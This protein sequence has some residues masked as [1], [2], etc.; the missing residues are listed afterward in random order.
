MKQVI[1]Q[2]GWGLDQNFWDIDKVEF[3]KNNWVWQDNERGYFSKNSNQSKW[4][5][6]SSNHKI[7][8]IICHS[9][10]FHL[11]EEN[12]FREASHI[13]LINSFNDFLP[14]SKKRN[15][16]IRSLRRMEKQIKNCKAKSMLK[17][18]INRSFIPNSLN[19]EFQTNYY[20][21]LETIDKSI[22]LRDFKKLYLPGDLPKF[23][24]KDCNIIFI[25]SE[26]DLILDK[27]SSNNFLELL[28]KTLDKTPALIRLENQG[29][30]LTNVNLYEII[31]N[32]LDN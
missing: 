32:N 17:E 31:I 3:E 6:N 12:L 5:S 28:N 27:D 29:H 25:Q 22:L 20:K 13:V 11:I 10:G 19:T 30:C 14:F 16:I 9:L 26:D 7:K 2:H 15:L 23:L 21:N 24:N 8:M 18:F 4:I 1:T